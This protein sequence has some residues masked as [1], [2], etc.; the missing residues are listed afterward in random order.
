MQTK[1]SVS[2]GLWPIAEKITKLI[3]KVPGRRNSEHQLEA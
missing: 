3:V 2:K 1:A